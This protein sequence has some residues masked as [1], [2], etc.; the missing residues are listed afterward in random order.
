MPKPVKKKLSMNKENKMVDLKMNGF[1]KGST[2]GKGGGL[3]TKNSLPQIG[4]FSS[5][6][7]EDQNLNEL[8]ELLMEHDLLNESPAAGKKLNRPSGISATIHV[9]SKVATNRQRSTSPDH[10]D[11]EEVMD[12]FGDGIEAGGGDL[13]DA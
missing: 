8:D 4:K 7:K 9:T 1:R 13:E 12:E 10:F 6:T 5:W 2:N 11:L 3:E